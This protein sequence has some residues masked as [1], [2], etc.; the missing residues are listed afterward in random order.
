MLKHGKHK[1]KM[2]VLILICE[3]LQ[4]LIRPYKPYRINW[5]IMPQNDHIKKDSKKLTEV[6]GDPT[7]SE[8][9]RQRL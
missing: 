1:K 9:Q 5:Q 4:R 8:E 6:E 2:L 7:Y 3:N